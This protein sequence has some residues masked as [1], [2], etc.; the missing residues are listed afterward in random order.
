MTNI[1]EFR[2]CLFTFSS[3]ASLHWPSERQRVTPDPA[4]KKDKLS[5]FREPFFYVLG[6]TISRLGDVLLPPFLFDG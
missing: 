4:T 5:Y 1:V 6:S 2:V 3:K